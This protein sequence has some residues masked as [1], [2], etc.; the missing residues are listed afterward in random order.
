MVIKSK[1][2]AKFEIIKV[3]SIST[4]RVL[5]ILTLDQKQLR[6][7]FSQHYLKLFLKKNT[8]ISDDFVQFKTAEEVII[9]FKNYGKLFFFFGC[10]RNFFS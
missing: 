5:F 9:V 4:E 10:E 8:D 1:I 6:G 3:L 2:L 7:R